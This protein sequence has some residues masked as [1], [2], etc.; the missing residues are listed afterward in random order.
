MDNGSHKYDDIIN[1]PRHISKN[2]PQMPLA[3][4]AAQFSPFAALTGHEAAIRETE[5]RTEAFAELDED[6]KE[7]LDRRLSFL[8]RRL[9]DGEQEITV[10]Y[11]EADERKSGGAYRTK[12]GKA[13]RI[14]GYRRELL[15]ADGTSLPIEHIFSLEGDLFGETDIL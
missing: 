1:L 8:G 15:F 4:R 7:W 12:Q 13:K 14:E 9:E 11:F 5:R 10:T 3:D 6:R 2:H